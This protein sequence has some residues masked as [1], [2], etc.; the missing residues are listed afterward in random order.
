MEKIIFID[1]DGTLCNP[2][3]AVPESAKEAIKRARQNGHQVFACT[4]RSKPELT[5]EIIDIGLDGIIGAGGGYI[6]IVGEVLSHQ[7]MPEGAVRDII[8]YFQEHQIGYYLESNDGLF[9]SQ[10][11]AETIHRQVTANFE[12]NSLDYKKAAAEFEWFY[13]ILEASQGKAI[14]YA[15]VN[16]VSFISN[17]HPYQAVAEKYQD[18]F[19]MYHTTVPQFGP[20]SGEIAIKG[21]DKAIAVKFVLDQLG[22]RKEQALAYG[23]GNNDIAMFEAVGYRVAMA[24][25]TNELK[26]MADEI[27]AIA[28]EE[29]IK[30]SFIRNGLY[31]V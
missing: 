6:E 5:D 13:E 21:I 26:A 30:E 10:N 20:E 24:N 28:D 9:G 22:L 11:C 4:G 27:T 17:G 14:D 31:T 19:A 1:V 18:A 12:K 8:H 7:R 16:K 3:G 29:G 2:A 23:D 25:G 15:N